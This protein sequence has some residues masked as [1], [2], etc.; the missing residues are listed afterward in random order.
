MWNWSGSARSSTE[1]RGCDSSHTQV[2]AYRILSSSP[3]RRCTPWR[4][5]CGFFLAE[6]RG[7]KP[8]NWRPLGPQRDSGRLA[9]P[10]DWIRVSH[11]IAASAVG[12]EQWCEKRGI[13]AEIAISTGRPRMPR[14]STMPRITS[15]RTFATYP[16]LVSEFTLWVCGGLRE[17]GSG[18][19]RGASC[20]SAALL[21]CDK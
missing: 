12:A 11:G 7:S 10:S 17:C 15:A 6:H 3:C 1:V 9:Q 20:N 21:S 19:W 8:V 18:N 13:S 4:F 16:A 14:D 5:D 2:C